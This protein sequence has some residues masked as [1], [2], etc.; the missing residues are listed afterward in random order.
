MATMRALNRRRATVPHEFHCNGG[1]AEM[2]KAQEQKVIVCDSMY[3]G[4]HACAYVF[5]AF[6]ASDQSSAQHITTFMHKHTYTH[7]PLSAG[8]ASFWTRPWMMSCSHT[9]T[10]VHAH[11]QALER[12][13]R[14]ILDKA[15]DDELLPEQ[16]WPHK[17]ARGRVRP[18]PPPSFTEKPDFKVGGL[19]ES[20]LKELL[21]VTG[22][23]SNAALTP[24]L[25]HTH[26]LPH[27][28]T[29][30]NTVTHTLKH[31]HKLPLQVTDTKSNMLRIKATKQAREA[32]QYDFKDQR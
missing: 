4:K 21:Q 15:L 12:R 31:T 29:L 19:C 5:L 18:A 28:R 20:V 7:R 13:Q 26:T 30:R 10:H 24:N 32:G 6:S 2:R 23:E 25:A 3:M 17:S 11:T 16:R 1:N 9:N 22:N 27:T 14:I 8:S